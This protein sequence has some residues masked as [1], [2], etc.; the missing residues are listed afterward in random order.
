MRSS[1]A[2]GV[3]CWSR[4]DF[5]RSVGTWQGNTVGCERTC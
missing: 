5:G 2:G 4:D 3:V 1:F